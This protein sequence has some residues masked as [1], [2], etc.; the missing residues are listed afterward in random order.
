MLG[1][2]DLGAV[3]S[4]VSFVAFT[5]GEV[6]MLSF[7]TRILPGTGPQRPQPDREPDEASVEGLPWFRRKRKP[8]ECLDEISPARPVNWQ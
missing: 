5:G 6:E 4:C 3:Q 8:R 7:D 1:D 2:P